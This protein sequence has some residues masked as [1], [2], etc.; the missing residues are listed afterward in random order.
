MT[1]REK[2]QQY[3]S[4]LDNAY[5]KANGMRDRSYNHEVFNETRRCL[6]HVLTVLNAHDNALTDAEASSEW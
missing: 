5:D 6:L 3:I 4:E 1:Y 2:L